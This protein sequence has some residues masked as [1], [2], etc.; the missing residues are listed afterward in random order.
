MVRV[1]TNHQQIG[2]VFKG[3]QNVF[4]F[5]MH[6][7]YEVWCVRT[8]TNAK[9]YATLGSPLWTPYNVLMN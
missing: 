4:F 6:G 5:S 1:R 9:T 8:S 7:P 3:Y 2:Y